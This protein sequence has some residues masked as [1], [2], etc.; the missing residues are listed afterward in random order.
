MTSASRCISAEEVKNATNIQLPD[1]E[2][3]YYCETK[4]NINQ[5]DKI[6]WAICDK[7]CFN[8]DDG[9]LFNSIDDLY[10]SIITSFPIAYL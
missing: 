10:F 3:H 5:P 4:P 7:G 9:K 6:A 1:E 8:L 2:G